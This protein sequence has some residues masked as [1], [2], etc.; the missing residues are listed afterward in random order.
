MASPSVL[1][2]LS[3]SAEELLHPQL[4]GAHA[5]QLDFNRSRNKPGI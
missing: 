3:Q 2:S 1:L 5:H 4:S